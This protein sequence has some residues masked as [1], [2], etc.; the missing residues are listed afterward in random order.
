[1]LGKRK[2]IPYSHQA[3]AM[4]RK[5]AMGSEPAELRRKA[6]DRLR[7][8]EG[9]P[10]EVVSEADA[11]A[12][13]HELQV[14]QIELEMQNEEL[15]RA[16]AAAEEASEKYHDLFDFAPVGYFLWDIEGRILE[17]NLA[18]ASLLG[19]NRKAVIQKRFGQFV[20]EEN[21]PAFADFCNRVLTTGAQESCEVKL[22]G[23]GPPVY[24]LVEGM[25]VQ[26]DATRVVGQPLPDHQG[27]KVCR[28]AVIDIT[29]QNRADELAAANQALMQAK[30][31]AEAANE[32]K[33]RF[34]A[35]ISHELRT[36]MNAILGM[37]ELALPRQVD[38][39]A[40]DFLQTASESAGLLLVL[41]NDLLDSAK[42][43]SGKLELESAPFS[44]R[45][46]LGQIAQV[47]AVRASEKGVTFSCVIAPELPDAMVGDQARLRQVLFNLAGN[48]IKFTERGEVTVSARVSALPSPSG[49]GTGGEGGAESLS[50]ITGSPH[51]SPLRAPT[52]GWS[53]EADVVLEFAV[54]DTGIGIQRSALERIFNP[55][56]QADTSTTRRFGGTGLGLSISSGL[57][58]MMG[59]R[60]W[61]ESQP[62]RGSTF[63]FTVRLPLAKE[64]PPQPERALRISTTAASRL[65]ILLV[66]DNPAN[67][68][69]AA[70]FLGD[71]GHTVESA[72]DGRHGLSMAQQNYY[73]VILM[74]VQM[75]GMDGL[76]ATAA[77]RAREYAGGEDGKRVPIIAMTAH[78]MKGDRDR[79]LAAGMDGYLSKPINGHEMIGLVESLARGAVPVTQ[80]A[81]ETPDTAETSPQATAVVFNLEKALRRCSNSKDMIREM[82]QCFFDDVDN[83]LPQMRTA[84]E[85]GDLVEVGRLGHRMKGTVV[86][87]GARPAEEAALRVEQFC[88]SSGGALSEAEE[89]IN[90]LQHECIALRTALNE[91]LP[92][93]EPMQGD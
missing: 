28:A 23:D 43:E 45:R 82:I 29:Q 19:L 62:G 51:P 12:L 89:A 4:N 3:T 6:E 48:A 72:E 32:A 60:I 5:E 87:L 58:R 25:A 55:F 53:G 47:L 54:R 7:G 9:R 74:D 42:I 88:K 34:L 18:G 40:K 56:V 35:N 24:V 80:L 41:L 70:C 37:V 90:A 33:S 30:L 26:G 31:A 86:Y 67:Q 75:P 50:P 68:K 27:Q 84:L 93:A 92:A 16:Q 81:A 64:A 2:G 65:R 14:H 1:M 79:C 10:A 17:V 36:P 15:Q 13:I 73:D 59:G 69:L 78:A 52:E 21:R 38:P 61:I 44:L 22:L 46:V 57:V 49:R 76:E 8:S 77:I 85:K 83:L 11:R 71:R 91:H 20:A 66:E 63:Y 39:A